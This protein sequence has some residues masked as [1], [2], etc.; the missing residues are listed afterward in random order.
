MPS[1]P[2]ACP[3]RGPLRLVAAQAAA[4][5][6]GQALPAVVARRLGGR[7][8]AKVEHAYG[9]EGE[10]WRA[11]GAA[12]EEERARRDQ[13]SRRQR[14]HARTVPEMRP[15][16][17][18]GFVGSCAAL[19]AV[20]GVIEGAIQCQ[21]QGDSGLAQ[22][23]AGRGR[24]DH[25]TRERS[26]SEGQHDTNDPCGS[27]RTSPSNLPNGQEPAIERDSSP[28]RECFPILLTW[29]QRF[30][31]DVISLAAFPEQ[32]RGTGEDRRE[33]LVRFRVRE[34]PCERDFDVDSAAGLDTV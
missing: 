27:P 20:W 6:L 11:D 33:W 30:S 32:S 15:C 21:L 31:C 29:R 25:S 3:V 7:A 4:P 14:N 10:G 18:V 16:I 22:Q 23:W 13:R 26:R 12:R 24:W 5:Q 9:V 28:L 17:Q 1:P 2:A 8:Q 19:R 34:D